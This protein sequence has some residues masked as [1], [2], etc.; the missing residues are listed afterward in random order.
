ML[1]PRSDDD[2]M[3]AIQSESTDLN[4]QREAPAELSEISSE[5]VGDP[6]SCAAVP[7]VSSNAQFDVAPTERTQ[8]ESRGAEDEFKT[9]HDTTDACSTELGNIDG[10]DGGEDADGETVDK[11]RRDERA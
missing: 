4:S 1:T 3:L 9:H 2:G 7:G 10:G 5:S 11:L 8:H 6:E